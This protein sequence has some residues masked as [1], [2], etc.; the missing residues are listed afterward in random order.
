MFHMVSVGACQV[1]T[2]SGSADY[3]TSAV[4][5][6]L[7]I[8]KNAQTL[9]FVTPG[10]LIPGSN[11][12]TSAAA[13]TDSDAGFLLSAT[14]SSGLTLTYASLDPTV[15]DVDED[16]RVTWIPNIAL[17][18][19]QNVCRVSV[20]QAGD[21]NY[22]ALAP[23]TITLTATHVASTPPPGGILTEPDVSGGLGRTGGKANFGGSG[24]GVKV[25]PTAITITPFS[26]GI[27]IGKKTVTLKIAYKVTVKGALVS[28]VQA[29]STVYG[30]NTKIP[31]NKGGMKG[32]TFTAT[33]SCK[34]NADAFKWFKA[35]NPINFDAKVVSDRRWPT[36][37]LKIVGKESVKVG[38]PLYT[39]SKTYH[40]HIG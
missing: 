29:C 5:T 18:P 31:A 32:K 6:T 38:K 4:T 21:A 8:T 13:A 9:S 36:T 40:L 34:L 27:L 11:P 23:Q 30:T 12:A 15:C 19:T 24:F 22:L 7:N 10:S 33:V 2:T 37:G 39:T 35:G 26:T 28:K 20:S 25:T 17:K 14:S 1:V 16:G 3:V